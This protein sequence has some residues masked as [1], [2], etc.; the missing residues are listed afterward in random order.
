M[1]M[2]KHPSHCR[3]TQLQSWL[4]IRDNDSIERLVVQGKV[5]GTRP[6]GRSPMRWTDQ[7]KSAVGTRVS[8]CTRQSANRHGDGDAGRDGGRSCG[9]VCPPLPPMWMPLRD[10]DRS[11]KSETT[12]KSYSFKFY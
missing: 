4:E 12:E 1:K 5:E 10:H 11:A 6:R 3:S 2:K 9:E 7:V 8:D